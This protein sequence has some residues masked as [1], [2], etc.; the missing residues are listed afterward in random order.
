MFIHLHFVLYV[1]T[2]RRTVHL[3]EPRQY[4]QDTL[5]SHKTVFI[6]YISLK[7]TN[8]NAETL[9]HTRSNLS[10]LSA[11]FQF[12][13]CSTIYFPL[14]EKWC[15]VWEWHCLSG[16]VTVT[17]G[18]R[19]IVNSQLM[20]WCGLLWC[21]YQSLIL[22]A[23]IHCRASI[24]DKWCIATFLQIWWRNKLILIL[25]VMSVS[26]FSANIIFLRELFL[27]RIQNISPLISSSCSIA[28]A[29]I[30]LYE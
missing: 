24:A 14:L 23:P 19:V 29:V 7:M 17:K 27:E 18:G 5:K 1:G 16:I 30:K 8:F 21:F 15:V 13:L 25:D 20:D 22:T 26:P 4:C 12:P 3:F 6:V 11:C 10:G 9:F 2:K 28:P